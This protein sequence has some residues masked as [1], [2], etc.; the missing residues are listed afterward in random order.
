MSEERTR[1][2][3][4]AEMITLIS[5]KPKKKTI[6]LGY[7]ANKQG[8]IVDVWLPGGDVVSMADFDYMALMNGYTV[9]SPSVVRIEY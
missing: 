1:R 8:N 4:D 9:V 2:W 5:R 3:W 7:R 6:Q